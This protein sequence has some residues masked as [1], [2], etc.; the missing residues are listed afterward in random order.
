M[1]TYLAIVGEQ[2]TENDDLSLTCLKRYVW[3]AY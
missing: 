2:Y 3:A 1:I